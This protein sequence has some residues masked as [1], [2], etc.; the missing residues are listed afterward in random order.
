MKD[1]NVPERYTCEDATEQDKN[2]YTYYK[3][4]LAKLSEDV[5][6][7][8]IDMYGNIIWK[9]K[10]GDVFDISTLSKRVK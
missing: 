4:V 6:P 8:V 9:G 2:I 5:D 3:E 7:C 10:K 1:L